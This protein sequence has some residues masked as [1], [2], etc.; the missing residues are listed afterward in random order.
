MNLLFSPA[1]DPL[2]GII[3]DCLWKTGA[4]WFR[5]EK[6]ILLSLLFVLSRKSMS[7]VDRISD[8]AESKL[9]RLMDSFGHVESVWMQSSFVK[10]LVERLLRGLEKTP[11]TNAPDAE[12]QEKEGL[13]SI[14]GLPSV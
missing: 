12:P 14:P 1:I 7:R 10:I 2:Y 13:E 9:S 6:K 3:I 11:W 5:E 8:I 4:S